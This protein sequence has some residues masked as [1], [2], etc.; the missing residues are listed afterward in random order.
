M[1][2]NTPKILTLKEWFL[3]KIFTPVRKIS[4]KKNVMKKKKNTH[5][6]A[7]FVTGFSMIQAGTYISFFAPQIKG[8]QFYNFV[9]LVIILNTVEKSFINNSQK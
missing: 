6:P 5:F 4:R 3:S 2:W 9:P 8:Q 7:N 1:A